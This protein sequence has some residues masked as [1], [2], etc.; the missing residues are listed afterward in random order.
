MS[1]GSYPIPYL[2][3]VNLAGAE[4]GSVLPGVF[5][6]D[7]TFNSEASLCYFAGR[8]LPL[9]RLPLQWERLQPVLRKPLDAQYLGLLK[10]VLGWAGANGNLLIPEIHNFARYHGS[11]VSAG[12]LADL[13]VRLSVELR[14]QPAIY[15]Y[16][17][18]NEPHHIRGWK[19]ISQAVLTVIRHFGDNQRIL[20]PGDSW[21]S[22]NRWRA[23]HGPTGWIDDPADNFLY[24]AHQ[25]FDFDE[26]GRYARTYDEELRDNPTLATVG[27]SRVAG[28]IEWCRD[29]HVPGFLAEYGVPGS[30]A[31]WLAV[32]D[33]FLTTLDAAGISGCYWAAGEWW[34][35]Y[36]LSVQP[37]DD[38]TVDR[39]QMAVLQA[40]TSGG[41][42]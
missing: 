40:H 41:L 32:L 15:A 22:A 17:L 24:E 30:D 36:P 16:G 18:M 37:A 35:D 25:Y 10:N 29:N 33:D 9:I 39:P 19:E 6:T 23:V 3:G 26:S 11:I 4:F 31:R 8:D 21:S 38:F 5:Q 1:R 34:G 20:V 2:R 7:Y 13:W 28:F 42:R 27:S 12:D 14:D